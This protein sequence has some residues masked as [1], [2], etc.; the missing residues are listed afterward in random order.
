[1]SKACIDCEK[2]HPGCHDK[3][4]VYQKYSRW[5]RKVRKERKIKLKYKDNI[6]NKLWNG[7]GFETMKHYLITNSI[8]S[9]NLKDKNIK[10]KEVL[11]L[12]EERDEIKLGTQVVVDISVSGDYVLEVVKIERDGGKVWWQIV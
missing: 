7:K 9:I 8:E 1:M 10:N 5:R 12:I 2:R 6:S 3:C 11:N 4:E